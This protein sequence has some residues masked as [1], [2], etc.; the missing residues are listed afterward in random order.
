MERRAREL[1]AKGRDT[2]LVEL[3]PAR[4]MTSGVFVR[5]LA[6][7][8]PVAVDLIDEAVAALGAAVASAVALLDIPLVVIGGGLADR[9][10]PAFVSRVEQAV[11]TD[12][13]PKRPGLRVVP[14]ALGDRGGAIGAAL[15]AAS[16][17][18]PEATG[19]EEEDR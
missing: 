10:G 1:E 12:V 8:D 13:F 16:L 2:V 19:P 14:G 17:H 18:D 11:L 6:A 4:R 9:L 5:A 15:V 7:G 3:A